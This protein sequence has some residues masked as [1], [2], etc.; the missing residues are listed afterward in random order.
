M[1]LPVK[2]LLQL[3][4]SCSQDLA[5]KVHTED[6]NDPEAEVGSK[7]KKGGKASSKAKRAKTAGD[8]VEGKTQVCL[9]SFCS[10]QDCVI[11]L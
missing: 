2:I 10:V 8:A 1:L 7:R 4:V 3:P 11:L 5:E 9:H 6:D